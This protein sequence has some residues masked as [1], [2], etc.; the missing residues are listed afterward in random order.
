MSISVPYEMQIYVPG[1]TIV[2]HRIPEVFLFSSET[3]TLEMYC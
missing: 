1:G 3:K 2:F